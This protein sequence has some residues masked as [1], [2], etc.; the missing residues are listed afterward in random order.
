MSFNHLFAALTIS[1]LFCACSTP[2]QRHTTKIELIANT[3]NAEKKSKTLASALATAEKALL[4]GID[5]PEQKD[6]YNQAIEDVVTLWLATGKRSQ[7]PRELTVQDASSTYRLQTSWSSKLRFDD[8]ILARTVKNHALRADIL[9]GG[10]GVPYVARWKSSPDRRKENPFM[11]AKGYFAS[12]TATLDFR[13]NPSGQRVASLV[14]HNANT[15][16]KVQL[17]Q[18]R[19]P[20]AFNQS[21]LAEHI[22]SLKTEFSALGALL[23]PHKYI[24]Q[25]SLLCISPPDP[26]KVPIIFVHGLASEP[27]TWQ[28]VYNELRSDPVIR[29]R[30]QIYFFRYP[31]GVPVLYSAAKLREK[32]ALLDEELHR[33]GHNRYADQM[34]LIGHS[35]GG[36][37]TKTQVQDSGKDLWLSFLDSHSKNIKLNDQQ[38]ASLQKYIQ[39]KPN[40]HISRVVFIATPHRGSELA[41]YWIVKQLRKLIEAPITIIRAPLIALDQGHTDELAS[42]TIDKLF[43]SGIPTSMENLS[44]NSRYVKETINLPLRKGLKVHSIVGNLKGLELTDPKCSDGVVPYSSSHLGE[45]QSELV[46]PYGHSAHEHNLAIEEIN[47]IIHLHLRELQ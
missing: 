7:H 31:S 12:V 25:I 26:T 33:G 24:E 13:R 35:M 2:Q 29:K 21:A 4:A 6:I 45:T 16:E 42:G 32:M 34:M 38:L 27:R 9:R 40:P 1:L 37:V 30:C 28:N 11:S 3:A 19:Y 36:L 15:T 43:Q 14:L 5:T 47:R 44:P 10:A 20:L 46:V 39:F 17:N 8:L 41:D 22:L 23:S 18:H